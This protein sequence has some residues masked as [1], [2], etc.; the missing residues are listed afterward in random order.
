VEEPEGRL[1]SPHWHW[2]R[3]LKRVFSIDMER[4]PMCQQG[5]LRIIAAT[6]EVRV[7]QKILRHLKLAVDPPPIAPA[8]QAAF[9]WDVS[10][11]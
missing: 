10:S 8:Q 6:T 7:I 11:P 9:A 3:L 4:C 5:R 2:A 1:A